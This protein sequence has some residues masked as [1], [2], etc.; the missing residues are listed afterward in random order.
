MTTLDNAMGTLF[1]STTKPDIETQ[2][3]VIKDGDSYKKTALMDVLEG[4]KSELIKK[5]DPTEYVDLGL[6]SGTLWATKNLGASSVTD[7]GLYFSYAN[8]EGHAA[9]SGYNFNW[10]NYITT[11]GYSITDTAKEISVPI[12]HDAAAAAKG[13]PYRIPTT[14]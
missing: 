2:A 13:Y 1:A 11:E 12:N 7:A 3:L 10:D 4:T 5:I 8:T 6:P 9:G 14:E